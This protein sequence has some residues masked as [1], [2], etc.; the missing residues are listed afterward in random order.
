MILSKSVKTIQLVCPLCRG[1]GDREGERDLQLCSYRVSTFVISSSFFVVVLLPSRFF[2]FFFSNFSISY[3]VYW[4]FFDIVSWPDCFGHAGTGG[5]TVFHT[6]T[7]TLC[8][9]TRWK[10]EEE[11]LCKEFSGLILKCSD[12]SWFGIELNT[13]IDS[14]NELYN[15][16]VWFG[17]T[18]SL[19]KAEC[20]RYYCLR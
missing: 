7:H 8:I 2:C 18:Y 9:R 14:W 15:T 11:M 20:R 3:R 12:K 1:G 13:T 5:D 4:P 17:L 6:H 16:I 19:K 10:L